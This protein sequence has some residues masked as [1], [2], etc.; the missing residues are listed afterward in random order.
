MA[1][2]CVMVAQLVELMT[3]ILEIMCSGLV[4]FAHFKFWVLTVELGGAADSD[5]VLSECRMVA[6]K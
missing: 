6:Y 4:Y 5:P 1:A 3:F 2:I